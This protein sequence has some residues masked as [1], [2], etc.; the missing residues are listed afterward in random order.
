MTS[1][2]R[3][4]FR[5]TAAVTGIAALGV[6]FAGSAFADEAQTKSGEGFQTASV[7]G[8]DTESMVPLESLTSDLGNAMGSAPQQKAQAAS[9]TDALMPEGFTFEMPSTSIGTAQDDTGMSSLGSVGSMGLEHMRVGTAGEQQFD[10]M[11]MT[12]MMRP[13]MEHALPAITGQ[14]MAAAQQDG[15]SFGSENGLPEPANGPAN[16]VMGPAGGSVMPAIAAMMGTLGEST[17]NDDTTS[18]HEFQV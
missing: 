9:P 6:G 16:E 11:G 12:P 15:A 8:F 10:D 18:N 3:R 17:T 14:N 2:A 7:D 1:M 4:T 13:M 5:A